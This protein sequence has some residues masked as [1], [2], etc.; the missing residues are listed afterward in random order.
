MS[1]PALP[2]RAGVDVPSHAEVHRVYLKAG[3]A[4]SETQRPYY[5]MSGQADA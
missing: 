2:A 4:H 3:T 1:E 5:W